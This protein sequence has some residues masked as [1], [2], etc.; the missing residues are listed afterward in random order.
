MMWHKF[1]LQVAETNRQTTTA[2]TASPLSGAAVVNASH[3]DDSTVCLSKPGQLISIQP[4]NHGGPNILAT[5]SPVEPYSGNT[6]RL[7]MSDDA[8]DTVNFAHVPAC[9][10]VSSTPGNTVSGVPYQENGIALNP[11]EPEENHYES[12]CQSLE[13]QDV[14]VNVV[15]VSGEVSILNLDGQ[16]SSPQ[17]QISSS[18]TA[19]KITSAS[20]LSTTP[21]AATASSLNAHSSENYSTEP[22]PVDISSQ[23]PDPEESGASWILTNNTKYIATAAGVAALALLITWKLKN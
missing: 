10:A 14:R 6:D 3:F 2:A 16:T 19:K 4:Q 8:Q 7:E 23:S 18:D 22:V 17:A 13:R 9:S 5:N 12:P 20:P 11:N 1:L 21:T 15:H